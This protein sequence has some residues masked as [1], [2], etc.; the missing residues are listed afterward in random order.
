VVINSISI[1]ISALTSLD[2]KKQITND[3]AFAEQLFKVADVGE[4]EQLVVMRRGKSLE[5]GERVLIR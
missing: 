4:G 1:S 5:A 3:R 2:W